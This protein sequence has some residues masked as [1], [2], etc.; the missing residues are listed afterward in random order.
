MSKSVMICFRTS[1]EL[2]DAIEVI[3]KEERRSVSATIEKILYKHLQERKDFKPVE[4]EHRRYPRKMITAPALITEL[5]SDNTT[6]QVGIVVDISLDG[7]QI[8]IPDNYPYEIREEKETSRISI[9]FALP[10]YKRPITMQCVPKRISPSGGETRIGASL[11]DTDFASYQAL[12]N[13][14]VH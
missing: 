5:G 7:L 12:Q 1:E 8:S 4:Q 6:P 10:D 2:R 11:I 14:L 13:Y 3:A 9:V